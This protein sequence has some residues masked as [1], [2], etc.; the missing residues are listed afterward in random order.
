MWGVL[1]ANIT[2]LAVHNV[3]VVAEVLGV[4]ETEP[5]VRA[6]S[7]SAAENKIGLHKTAGRWAT[8]AIR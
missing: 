2:V 8:G 1:D 5:R 7:G 4:A 3:L 6:Q